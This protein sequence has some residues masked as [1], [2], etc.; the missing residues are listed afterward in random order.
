MIEPHMFYNLLILDEADGLHCS[1]TLRA[2]RGDRLPGLGV[3]P[4]GRVV[5]DAQSSPAGK[6]ES[7]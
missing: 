3:P 7:A 2:K 5:L 6:L 1:L 4:V